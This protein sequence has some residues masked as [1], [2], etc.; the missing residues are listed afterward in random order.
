MG[1]RFPSV[2]V[3]CLARC[4]WALVSAA[5]GADLPEGAVTNVWQIRR[6]DRSQ[7]T[8]SIP[9]DVLATV[10]FSNPP[11]DL[12]VFDKTDGTYV[13]TTHWPAGLKAG[14][15]VRI[16][17]HVGPGRFAPE[18]DAT[19][20]TVIGYEPLP[21]ARVADPGRLLAGLEDSEW[22]RLHG[23]V[24]DYT[25]ENDAVRMELLGDYCVV[26]LLFSAGVRPQGPTN[27]IGV[28]INVD[29]ACSTLFNANGQLTG[30]ALRVPRSRDIE[31]LRP[32]NAG[33]PPPL[34]EIPTLLSYR[35]DAR[36]NERVRVQGFVTQA[37]TNGS[38]FIQAGSN[39]LHVLARR[40]AAPKVGDWVE[41]AGFPTAAEHAP[42]LRFADILRVESR[43]GIPAPTRVPPSEL[44]RDY[45]AMLVRLQRKVVD[46][47]NLPGAR[48]LVLEPIG[49]MQLDAVMPV[50]A[51]GLP[52]PGLTPGCTVD[53]TGVY[54][55]SGVGP[56]SPS[57]GRIWMRG[58][59][60]LSVTARGPILTRYGLGI[61]ALVLALAL[62][63]AGAWV[64]LL[65]AIVS[66]QTTA[67]AERAAREAAM[68]RRHRELT[69]NATDLI[70]TLDL[71]GKFRSYNPAMSA[72][73]GIPKDRLA[74]MHL[75]ELVVPQHEVRVRQLLAE[76]AGGRRELA[77]VELCIVTASRR[78][79]LLE[80]NPRV[81]WKENQPA[82]VE[83]V[84]R[85]IT[86]RR[87]AEEELEDSKNRFRDLFEKSPDAVLVLALDGRILDANSAA[88]HL[89]GISRDEA[90]SKT[91]ADLLPPGLQEDAESEL[92]RHS[93][94][95]DGKIES[96]HAGPDGIVIPVETRISRIGY[97]GEQ[98]LLLHVRDSSDWQ[99][100]MAALR[101][102]EDRYREVVD[103]LEEGVMLVGGD[104]SIQA[105]NLSA[106][107]I[108]GL[109]ISV[110]LKSNVIRGDWSAVREDG[111][112]LAPNDYPVVQT[113]RTGVP[114]SRS[115]LGLPRPGGDGIWLSV[116]SRPVRRAP[117]GSV[118]AAVASFHD[119]TEERRIRGELVR[120]KDDA[121][122]ANRA[123]SEFLAHMSHEIRTP[124][125]GIVGMHD[126][127]LNTPLSEEQRG[128]VRAASGSVED[129]LQIISDLLDLSKIEAGKLV[130]APEDF[131]LA[132]L[133]QSTVALFSTRTAKAGIPI[134]T[135]IS[136]G[137]PDRIRADPQRLRQIVGNLL[138]NAVKFTLAGT[139]GIEVRPEPGPEPDIRRLWFT[140]SDTGIGIARDK[141]DLV[142]DAFTQADQSIERRFG[143]TGLG[144]SIC[145]RLVLLMAGRIWVESDPGQGS[146]FH[147]VV[148]VETAHDPEPEGP[149]PASPPVDS[150]LAAAAP[151][152]RDDA[153]V[154]I[155]E[156]HPVNRTW[157]EALVSKLGLATAVAGNGREALAGLESTRFDL[158]LMDLQMP[159]LDGLAAT[160]RWR[161]REATLGRPRIPIIAVTAH[162]LPR[163]REAC[164]AA[165]MDGYLTKP[166]RREALAAAIESH[167]PAFA[168][169]APDQPAPRETG[170]LDA[171]LL[172]LLR[173]T[174]LEAI[175]RIRR[176]IAAADADEIA[177]AV[178]YLKGGCALMQDTAL[179]AL[180]EDF[181]GDAKQRRIER[182][183]AGLPEVESSIENTIARHAARLAATA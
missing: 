100:A 173:V 112:R 114:S 152:R 180:L 89:H 90:L 52:M 16:R 159:E 18:L 134:Q 49:R 169:K 67:I 92:R 111:S 12:F 25:V 40:P 154:L 9:A 46:I 82:E 102:G 65:R 78:Q 183:V 151:R 30:F 182:I 62:F 165:G 81:F 29:G 101:D 110:L 87:L 175:A 170:R 28:E 38:L 11:G 10:S 54:E 125:G 166:L 105:A 51:I 103:G 121:E 44:Q 136:P 47:R 48:L 8:N 97:L 162:A 24:S 42:V 124:L 138:H 179:T 178:H 23:V 59:S 7:I 93:E 95:I 4:L 140:V 168:P 117:N 3:V 108:L 64:V 122:H 91:F 109:P 66:R 146:R 135:R 37:N 155:V 104:G 116:N 34:R 6:L 35:A 171:E 74:S 94:S 118:V 106:C 176:A 26:Q 130:L 177:L 1:R 76:A 150:G 113:L 142:F 127:L 148:G 161:E 68:E 5:L 96:F 56:E 163:D 36:P 131:S 143:G 137:I 72:M 123:K 164:R 149:S 60:D 61:F 79:V 160:R 27:W 69:E 128:F 132:E 99:R 80:I 85:D 144:L 31:Q 172:D 83:A 133:V 156:D 120:A 41:L 21:P 174:S 15:R 50:H 2:V 70:F 22:V 88:C 13:W 141:L 107:R 75:S 77:Q 157:T 58:A 57:S 39:A 145:R 153:R 126:I 43:P 19:N 98:A 181:N 17:G 45:H 55:Q 14:D 32:A 139:I 71:D 86:A 20:I 33:L 73:T 167:L 158:V 84:G 147:F 119:I 129:L 53:V 115:V 63:G